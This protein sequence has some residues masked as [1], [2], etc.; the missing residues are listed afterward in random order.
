M[1]TDRYHHLTLNFRFGALRHAHHNPY[2]RAVNIC[3]QKPAGMTFGQQGQ[4]EICS[5]S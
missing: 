4:C 3:I 2:T 1:G 5:Y